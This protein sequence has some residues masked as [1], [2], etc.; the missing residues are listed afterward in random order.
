MKTQRFLVLLVVL[1][2]GFPL[3]AYADMK[4]KSTYSTGDQTN[5]NTLYAKGQRQRIESGTGMAIIS[6]IQSKR[7]RS[8]IRTRL[9]SLCRR[10][11]RLQIRSH[12]PPAREE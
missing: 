4:V 2:L 3:A 1:S 6:A 9:T 8:S 11:Q 5:E 10:A 7:F 12:L